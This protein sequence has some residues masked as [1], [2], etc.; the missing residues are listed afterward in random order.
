M[1]YIIKEYNNI[2]LKSCFLY[3]NMGLRTFSL[4]SSIYFLG[5]S[6]GNILYLS[7]FKRNYQYVGF[8]I[9][10]KYITCEV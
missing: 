6:C 4:I 8:S 9:F 5:Y 7:D 3:Y 2:V 1:L 10:I